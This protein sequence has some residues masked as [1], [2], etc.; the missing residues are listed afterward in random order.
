MD[1]VMRVEPR[2]G[3]GAL[4]GG[5]LQS[6]LSAVGGTVRRQPSAS[7]EESSLG[8]DHAGPLILVARPPDC[9]KSLSVA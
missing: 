7:Q 2:G 5:G 4:I 8:A 3:I 9:E 6:P 1:D